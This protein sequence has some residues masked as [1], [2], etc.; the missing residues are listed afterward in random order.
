MATV[1]SKDMRGRTAVVFA[2][3]AF[4]TLI[5]RTSGAQYNTAEIRGTVRDAQAGVIPGAVVTAVNVAS[6]FSVVRVS[7]NVGRFFLPA[8]PVGEY[9]LSVALPGFDT[10]TQ[11]GVV[12]Q[13]G[14]R[15]DLPVTLQVGQVTD[16]ITVSGVAPLLQMATAEVSDVVG[17]A[18]V[19]GLPLNGRQFLQLSVLTDGAVVPPGGTR[20][21]AVEQAGTLPAVE[22]QRSGHNIYLLDGVKVTDEYFNNLAISPSLEAIREFKIDKTMYPPEFG[23]KSSALINVVTKSG[24]NEYRALCWS[25]CATAPSTPIT[26]STIRARRSRRSISTSSGRRWAVRSTSGR[27]M[28]GTTRRSSI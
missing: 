18:Q 10:F 23:G 12:V 20:G 1:E 25:S 3:F 15:I 9:V 13:A 28:T 27:G 24:S 17:N 14:Q 6:G 7:D 5:A 16:A 4:S 26:T 22:G 21:A 19:V 2:C 8:L 11:Q